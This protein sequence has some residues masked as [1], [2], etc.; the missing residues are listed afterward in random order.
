MVKV[1]P[2]SLSLVQDT[3]SSGTDA[4]TSNG[5][6]LISGLQVGFT[7]Q[8]SLDGIN[9]IT[10]SGSTFTLSGDGPKQVTV[11]QIDGT[12]AVISSASLNFT[13]DTTVAAPN[14]VLASDTG[15]SNADGITSNGAV[16]VSLYNIFSFV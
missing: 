16:N 14:A 9:W 4:I 2:I 5:S 7:T 3:G 13:L 8:Y 11:R 10:V 1:K 6:V 12:G 15:A